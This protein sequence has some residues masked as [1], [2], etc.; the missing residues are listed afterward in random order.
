MGTFPEWVQARPIEKTDTAE[1]AALLNDVQEADQNGENYDADDLIEELSDPKLDC[2]RDTVGLWDG[3]T[4]VGYA[5][6]HWR[7][8]LVDVDRLNTDAG[9]RPAWRRRGLGR[10]LMSWM[11][12]RAGELHEE[13]HPEVAEAELNA[14]A[15]STNAGAAALFG[16]FGFEEAR[17]FFEMKRP[18]DTPIPAAELPDGLRLVPFGP[19]YDEALRL[20]HNEAF[21]DHWGSTPKDEETWK[22]WFTGSRAFRPGISFLVLDGDAI[23]AYANGF[24]YE[25]DTAV[26]GIREVYV[27]QVGTVRSHRGRGLAGVALSALMREAERTGFKRASLG[28]DADNPTGALGLYERLG[29]Q[30]HAKSITYRLPLT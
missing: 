18:F 10:A 21:M 8:H 7:A 28:V 4:M 14:G 2:E 5:V 12:G 23:V 29:F 15:I 1:W 17:Y 13:H 16:S 30:Q 25:A 24:E 11:I 6:L 9:V 19:E 26:T 27:G 20:V 22:V 3:G